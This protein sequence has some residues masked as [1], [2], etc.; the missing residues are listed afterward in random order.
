MS[1]PSNTSN[2]S[3]TTDHMTEDAACG[4][5]FVLAHFSDP[6]FARVDHIQ[7]S[8]L[9]TKR[10]LGYLRW[11]LKRQAQH[12]SEILTILNEDLQRTKPD[13]IVIT[14]DLTQL[15]L[16][17]EFA[18]VHEWL[19]T[20]GTGE[21]VTIVPGNHDTYIRTEWHETFRHWLEYMVADTEVQQESPIHC[22]GDMFPTLR[23]R[24]RVALIG[25]NTA[26]PS[27][28][29]LA[30]GTVGSEQ[31]EKLEKLLKQLSGQSLFRILL[32]HHPPV[33]NIVS[34][35]KSLTDSTSLGEILKKYGVELVLF[36]HSHKRVYKSLDWPS[37]S[38][39]VIGAPSASS[40]YSHDERRSCYYLYTITPSA[41]GWKVHVRERVFS[42]ETWCFVNG[43]IQDFSYPAQAY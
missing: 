30:I 19:K 7:A 22:L 39:P 20:I 15:G 42:V 33:K 17:V 23:I 25:I 24:D 11:K 3:S 36:G 43:G 41:A 16:P 28:P 13:H 10:L 4:K 26:H 31:L 12:N 2:I 38:I 5:S 8:D 37:G 40:L 1:P 35:R 27:S 9:L 18:T 29:H 34:W 21:T 6:H 32:I 14:G